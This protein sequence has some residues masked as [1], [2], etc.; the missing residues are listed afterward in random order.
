MAKKKITKAVTT[1]MKKQLVNPVKHDQFWKDVHSNT[2]TKKRK[3]TRAKLLQKS[4][5][6][7]KTNNRRGGYISFAKKVL[8]GL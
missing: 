8:G 7:L 4:T 6:L 1:Q 5:G 3:Q 2:K